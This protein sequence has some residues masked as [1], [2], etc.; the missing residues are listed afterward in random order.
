MREQ[1]LGSSR[2]MKQWPVAVEVRSSV[3]FFSVVRRGGGSSS[4]MMRL[5]C[6]RQKEEA[7]YYGSEKL[8][9]SLFL[10]HTDKKLK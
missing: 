10:N 8:R 9:L 1:Q 3:V 7:A 5:G 4:R 2:N 6:R